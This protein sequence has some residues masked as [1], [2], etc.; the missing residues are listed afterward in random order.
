MA[1]GAVVLWADPWGSS[2]VSTETLQLLIDD[3]LLR[4]VTDPTR[5][6]WIAPVGEQEPRPR[7]ATS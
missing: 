3:G 4:P 2:D 5:P 6:E 1:G 7:M